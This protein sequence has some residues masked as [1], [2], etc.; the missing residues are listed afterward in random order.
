MRYPARSDFRMSPRQIVKE[1]MIAGS[2]PAGPHDSG[3]GACRTSAEGF[4]FAVDI[5]AANTVIR[6]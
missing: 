1:I 3:A 4:T 2:P 5:G 6:P